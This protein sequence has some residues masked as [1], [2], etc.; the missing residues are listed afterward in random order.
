MI[1]TVDVHSASYQDQ[2]GAREEFKRLNENYSR[3]KV[4]F[5]DAVYGLSGLIKWTKNSFGWI[6]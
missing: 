1:L 3:L 2:E 4:I 5:G 6:L